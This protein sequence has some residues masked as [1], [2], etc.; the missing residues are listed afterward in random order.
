MLASVPFLHSP[1]S[2]MSKCALS[3]EGSCPP[4][5][6]GGTVAREIQAQTGQEVTVKVVDGC[7]HI[8]GFVEAETVATI[9]TQIEAAGILLAAQ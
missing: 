8:S 5:L 1:N 6:A 3:L 2:T 7:C 9:R 4:D